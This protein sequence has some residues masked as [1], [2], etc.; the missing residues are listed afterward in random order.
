M[1]ISGFIL[2]DF[3]NRV[4]YMMTLKTCQFDAAHNSRL[5]RDI[6]LSGQSGNTI[7]ALGMPHIDSF[8]KQPI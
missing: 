6:L 1:I 7:S 3:I 8:A 2:Y 5:Y 4:F